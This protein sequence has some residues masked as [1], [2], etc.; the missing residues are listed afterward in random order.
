MKKHVAERL[1]ERAQRIG[2]PAEAVT[3][4]G[5]NWWFTCRI[6]PGDEVRSCRQPEEAQLIDERLTL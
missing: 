2:L 6:K 3:L 5:R 4:D 1:V